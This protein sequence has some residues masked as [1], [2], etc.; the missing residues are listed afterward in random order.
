LHKIYPYN[1]CK[2]EIIGTESIKTTKKVIDTIL[3][4]R[5]CPIQYDNIWIGTQAN[6]AKINEKSTTTIFLPT[7]NLF[8]TYAYSNQIPCFI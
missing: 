6:S 8:D 7:Y 4:A 3:S 1:Y 5:F 2:A